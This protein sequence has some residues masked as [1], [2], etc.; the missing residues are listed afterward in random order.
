[1]NIPFDGQGKPFN[2]LDTFYI[3]KVVP[4]AFAGGTTNA[5]G[6]S[7]GTGDPLTLFNVTGDVLLGIY[8]VCT[9]DLASAGAGSV[10]VGTTSNLTGII[11]STTATEI[12]AGDVWVDTTPSVNLITSDELLFYI[13]PNGS[14]IVEDT[15]TADITAGNIYYVAL[16]RPLSD[17]ASVTAAV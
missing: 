16:W 15:I 4:S 8:G 7:G 11:P 17:G 14:D 12:D 1:M 6:D 5:R 2:S 13:V 9:V 10:A 3:A